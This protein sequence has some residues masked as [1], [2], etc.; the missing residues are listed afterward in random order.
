[1]YKILEP[2]L[3]RFAGSQE[4]TLHRGSV[5]CA[6]S[7]KCYKSKAAALE[8]W[9]SEK[10]YEIRIKQWETGRRVVLVT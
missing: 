9:S 2:L 3:E 5:L 8:C 7:T 4:S 6:K 10:S 1:M